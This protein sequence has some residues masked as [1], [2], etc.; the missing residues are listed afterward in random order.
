MSLANLADVDDRRVLVLD[1][2]VLNVYRFVL[3][4]LTC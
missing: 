4:K 1:S 2:T 3:Y